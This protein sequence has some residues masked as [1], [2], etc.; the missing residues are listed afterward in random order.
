MKGRMEDLKFPETRRRGQEFAR[1]CIFC[2]K[3]KILLG[4][5]GERILA[6]EKT[7]DLNTDM[8][9]LYFTGLPI[10]RWT[11]NQPEEEV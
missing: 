9:G 1:V 8:G 11:V 2:V 3:I 6:R 5:I 4:F 7:G 10:E